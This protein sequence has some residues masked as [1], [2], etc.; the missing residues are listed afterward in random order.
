MPRETTPDSWR[1]PQDPP[2]GVEI[3]IL[4][5]PRARPLRERV[6]HLRHSAARTRPRI[7]AGGVAGLALVVAVAMA[8]LGGVLIG[9][10]GGAAPRT[11]PTARDRGTAGVAAAYGFPPR[12]VAVKM[13]GNNPT[14]ARADFN[15]ASP[16]GR[17]DGMATAIFHRADGMWRPA[18]VAAEYSCPVRSL[19]RAVQVQLGVC[20]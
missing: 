18:L 17:Y 2:S 3:T 16:C 20:Q 19:P 13:L 7:R 4:A 6:S 15:R 14:Y 9:T 11:G 12:C 1:G 5:D 8:V 10:P